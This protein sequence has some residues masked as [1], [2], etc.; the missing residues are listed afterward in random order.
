MRSDMRELGRSDHHRFKALRTFK[1]GDQ[2]FNIAEIQ[3]G[4]SPVGLTAQLRNEFSLFAT[5]PCLAYLFL[6]RW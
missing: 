3:L 1:R 2:E 6:V 5:T 4:R